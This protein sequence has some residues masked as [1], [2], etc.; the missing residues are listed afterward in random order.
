MASLKD[1]RDRIKSVK[2]TQQITKTMKMVAAAKVRRARTACDAARPYSNR[3]QNTVANL[4][5]ST[6]SSW[7]PLLLRGRTYVKTVRL[8]VVGADRGLCGGFNVNLNKRVVMDLSAYYEA[9]KQVQI[10]TV[11]RKAYDLIKGYAATHDEV[12]NCGY[13]HG[14]W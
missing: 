11:G 2:N 12:G 14:C 10:V 9:G 5:R 8:I 4:A 13:L 6:N 7:A 1:L 3:L